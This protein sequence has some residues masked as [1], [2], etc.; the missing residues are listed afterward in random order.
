MGRVRALS[1][2]RGKAGRSAASAV[3]ARALPSHPRYGEPR[4]C[5]ALATRGGTRSRGSVSLR[6]P[7][8]SPGGRSS[9]RTGG[10]DR[11]P[12]R[13]ARGPLRPRAEPLWT[14]VRRRPGR[15]RRSWRRLGGFELLLRGLDRFARHVDLPARLSPPRAR[16]GRPRTPR[17]APC[18]PR[19]AARVRPSRRLPARGTSASRDGPLFR[20][21]QLLARGLFLGSARPPGPGFAGFASSFGRTVPLRRLQSTDPRAFRSRRAATHGSGARQ[22][23]RKEARGAS[24]GWPDV[25]RRLPGARRP[26]GSTAPLS[27]RRRAPRRAPC[28]PHAQ[29]P[30]APARTALWILTQLLRRVDQRVVDI[31]PLPVQL[32]DRPR[33][34][35]RLGEALDLRRVGARVLGQRVARGGE[36]VGRELIEPID[37]RFDAA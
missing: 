8:S 36:L 25:S 33:G 22:A 14:G 29:V 6:S 9:G 26:A 13:D 21:R 1:R 7:P 23:H 20:G 17:A 35:G 4:R 3:G 34:H 2:H 5:R 18:A 37:F 16:R 12:W 27:T 10:L 15:V 28:R 11:P 19:R 32:V 24:S 31:A 30:R